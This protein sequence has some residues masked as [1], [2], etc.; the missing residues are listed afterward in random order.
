LEVLADE[1]AEETV[2]APYWMGLKLES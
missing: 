1:V 2:P